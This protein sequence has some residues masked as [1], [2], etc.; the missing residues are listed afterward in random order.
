[1]SRTRSIGL[2]VLAAIAVSV[3]LSAC[4][5][6]SVERIDTTSVTDLSGRWNDADSRM[7]ADA[8]IDQSLNDSWVRQYA[9]ANNGDAPPIIVGEFRNRTY[10]HIPI[11]TFVRDLENALVRSEDVR[12]VASRDERVEVREERVDQ[13]QHAAP[14]TRARLARELGAKY[15]LQ[16]DVHAIEDRDGRNRVRFYQI[17]ATLIDLE[18]NAKIWVGQHKIKKFIQKSY[19]TG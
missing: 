19:I 13:Q 7:V 5:V 15:M 6:R 16:G 18:T 2:K 9:R 4:A 3:A 14:E 11:G 8:L 10:E 12:V 17:D 1:M